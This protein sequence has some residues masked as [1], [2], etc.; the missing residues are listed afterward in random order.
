M[1]TDRSML[2][3]CRKWADYALSAMNDDLRGSLMEL[4]LRVALA[5]SSMRTAGNSHVVRAAIGAAGCY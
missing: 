1:L 4:R 5:L 2:A 3:E